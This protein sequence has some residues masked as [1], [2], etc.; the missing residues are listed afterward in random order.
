[1]KRLLMTAA[2]CVWL[3]G[4]APVWAQSPPDGGQGRPERQ[5]YRGERDWRGGWGGDDRDDWRGH[6]GWGGAGAAR[7][8]A[9]FWLRSGDTRLGVR[10]DPSEPMRACVDAAITLMDKARSLPAAS[11]T[12]APNPGAGPP[13]AR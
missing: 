3:A 8:G 2:G 6:R 10:C 12:P 4:A 5:D 1:M 9:A 7:G 11:P 13:A